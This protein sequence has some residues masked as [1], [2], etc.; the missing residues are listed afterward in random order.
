MLSRKW[1]S[2]L[3]TLVGVAGAWLFALIPCRYK[4]LTGSLANFLFP[5]KK[6]F[7]PFLFS[8]SYV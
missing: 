3:K 5:V 6:M 1:N 2:N 8:C 7:F 4:Y